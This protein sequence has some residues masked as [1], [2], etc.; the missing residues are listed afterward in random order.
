MDEQIIQ[1]EITPVQ[2]AM[3]NAVREFKKQHGYGPSIR[4]LMTITDNKSSSNVNR[5]LNDLVT[6]GH[7]LKGYGMRRAISV[8]D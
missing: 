6:R 1:I 5:I 3:K 7:L 4:E 2:M 8:I